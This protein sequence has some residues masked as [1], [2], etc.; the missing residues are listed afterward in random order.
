MMDTTSKY[1]FIVINTHKK[2]SLMFFI[3]D[4]MSITIKPANIKKYKLQIQHKIYIYILQIH[5]IKNL[6]CINITHS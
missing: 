5:Y 1:I 6:N 3:H 4:L 2:T